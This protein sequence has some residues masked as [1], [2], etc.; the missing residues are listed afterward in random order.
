[1]SFVGFYSQLRVRNQNTNVT[2]GSHWSRS[3]GGVAGGGP[4]WNP[5]LATPPGLLEPT[6]MKTSTTRN[7]EDRGSSAGGLGILRQ[8]ELDRIGLSDCVCL[9]VEKRVSFFLVLQG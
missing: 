1:M 9:C 8:L 5:R 6:P 7:H 3:L 4:W 2:L